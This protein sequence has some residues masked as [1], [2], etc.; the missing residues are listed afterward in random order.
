MDAI[1]ILLQTDKAK[2]IYDAMISAIDTEAHDINGRFSGRGGNPS[3]IE[4]FTAHIQ[5]SSFQLE[6]KRYALFTAMQ[7]D[8]DEMAAFFPS[9]GNRQSH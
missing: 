6:Q 2:A 8:K 1:K 7:I 5:L 4:K 3:W 9:I